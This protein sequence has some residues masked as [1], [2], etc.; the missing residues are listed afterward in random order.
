MWRPRDLEEALSSTN[1]AAG[2]NRTGDKKQEE[3]TVSWGPEEDVKGSYSL[4]WRTMKRAWGGLVK[5]CGMAGSAPGV[6]VLE[7]NRA[8]ERGAA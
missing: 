2:K 1:I 8:F 6:L 4:C 5:D 3:R 7:V